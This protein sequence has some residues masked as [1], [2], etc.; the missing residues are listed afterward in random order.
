M[1][2]QKE[3]YCDITGERIASKINLKTINGRITAT[4]MD[5]GEAVN[6]NKPIAV[7]TKLL[8]EVT[9]T[10]AATPELRVF[11][12]KNTEYSAA[13]A[14]YTVTEDDITIQVSFAASGAPTVYP[15][16]GDNDIEVITDC[17]DT[18][19]APDCWE[20]GD[21]INIS[22]ANNNEVV[23]ILVDK[24]KNRYEFAD[25]AGKSNNVLQAMYLLPD[26]RHFNATKKEVT[27]QIDGEDFTMNK[28]YAGGWCLSD[29]R[30]YLNGDYFNNLSEKLKGCLGKIK[31]YDKVIAGRLVD[32]GELYVPSYS[33][34]GEPR[35]RS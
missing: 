29:L 25:G 35:P 27:I 28:Y 30:D 34:N 6:I 4:N 33:P 2:T 16:F 13:S 9:P 5:T 26:Q 10:S 15:V 12:I 8:V 18:N 31:L 3:L 20:P 32:V 24:Q 7:G 11:K 14:M 22:D 23:W 19:T 17:F 21:T 1:L